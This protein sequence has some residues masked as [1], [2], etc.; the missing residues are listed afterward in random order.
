M[1]ELIQSALLGL[2][3]DW[4]IA[5]WAFWPWIAV[6]VATFVVVS[7]LYQAYRV[8]GWPGLSVVASILTGL[9]G[10]IG[11]RLHNTQKPAPKP[12]EPVYKKRKTLKDVFNGFERD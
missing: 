5:V 2:I 6:G 3:P 8:G 11:G 4:L 9:G 7:L 12:A 10:Y 1:I